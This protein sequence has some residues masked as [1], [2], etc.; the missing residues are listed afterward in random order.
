MS[1]KLAA[2]AEE[3]DGTA[4]VPKKGKGGQGAGDGLVSLTQSTFVSSSLSPNIHIKQLTTL[5]TFADGNA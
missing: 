5:H 4:P 2:S 1:E 3:G